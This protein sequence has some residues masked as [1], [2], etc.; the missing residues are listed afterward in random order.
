[1]DKKDAAAQSG[2]LRRYGWGVG[3]A[4]VLACA[5]GGWYWHRTQPAAGE[6]NAAIAST[7][8][9]PANGGPAAGSGR[10]AQPVTVG[11]VRRQDIRV[12][13]AAIGNIIALNTATVRARVEGELR[14]IRFREGDEV[15]AGQLLAELDARPFEVQLAQAQGQRARDQALLKNALIDL[16]R[17]KIL[18]GRDA[19]ARQQVDTQE[20]LVQQLQGT[21]Q[22]DTA[23]VDNARLQLA[24]TKVVAPIS[25]KL[26]LK[27]ADLGN[28]VRQS[29]ANGIVTITQTQPAGVVLAVPEALL[30]RIRNRLKAGAPPVVEAWDR[31]QRQRLAVGTVSTTDNAIDA[32]TGTVKLKAEFPNADGT[33]F[34]NQFVNIVLQLDTLERATTVPN[35]ALQRGARGAFVYVV[36][37]D[38]TVTVRSVRPGAVDGDWTSIQGEVTPGEKVVTDGADRLREGARVEVIT[39]PA[40]PAGPNAASAP[41]ADRGDAAPADG[42][43]APASDK[44]RARDAEAANGKPEPMPGKAQKQAPAASASASPSSSVSSS[45]QVPASSP[46]PAAASP[47]AGASGERP[48]WLDRLPP[49]VQ[50]RYMKMNPEERKEF[51]QRLRE[52]RR[53][54]AQQNGG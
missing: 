34:P 36:K 14:A 6:G 11:V 47:G 1:M 19:I 53:E 40:R 42:K 17:Y 15:R 37:E 26:G 22:V 29:D 13:H 41:G 54:Q 51:I 7:A 12:T 27:Q 5:A 33:L 8:G 2:G 38:G 43:P 4:V 45:S 52:R 23:A 18:L 3:L 21:L 28:I 20:A 32:T 30:P 24:Y 48:A 25:G 31:E 49:D 9:G 10:R 44:P 16:D 39:P 46:S 35:A 50:E